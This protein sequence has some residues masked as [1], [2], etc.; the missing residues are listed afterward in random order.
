MKDASLA[1]LKEHYIKAVGEIFRKKRT[2]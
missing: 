1:E 2:H